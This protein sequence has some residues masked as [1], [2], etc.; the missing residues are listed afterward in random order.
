MSTAIRGTD[1]LTGSSDPVNISQNKLHIA[2]YVWDTNTLS[3]V[4][5]TGGGSGSGGDVTVTN[6]PSV[7]SVSQS[8]NW[9]VGNPSYAKRYDQVSDTLAYL[10]EAAAGSGVSDS[11]WRIQ[12]LDFTGGNVVVQWADGNSS[13]DNVWNNRASLTYV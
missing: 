1:E 8:G 11:T 10:G 12:R 5:Q 2:Q 3:W 9:T 4:R 6:F 7:Q 13:F